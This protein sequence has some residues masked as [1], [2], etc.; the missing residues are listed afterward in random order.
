LTHNRPS[1][2]NNSANSPRG[3]RTGTG[4]AVDGDKR[5]YRF[6]HLDLFVAIAR[7]A[8]GFNLELHGRAPGGNQVGIDRDLGTQSII[9][10]AG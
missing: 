3:Q 9:L 7:A 10:M 6:S 2:I 4:S 8:P 5:E 1:A